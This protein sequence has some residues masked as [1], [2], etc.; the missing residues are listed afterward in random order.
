MPGYNAASFGSLAQLVEQRTFNPLV[1]GSSPAR[2]TMNYQEAHEFRF[3][4]FLRSGHPLVAS[5]K[6]AAPPCREFFRVDFLRRPACRVLPDVDDRTGLDSQVSEE[7]DGLV[8]WSGL[9]Y[10]T[11]LIKLETNKVLPRNLLSLISLN[12][13]KL[14]E[15]PF[16]VEPIYFEFTNRLLTCAYK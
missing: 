7:A 16:I 15:S 12:E 8:A 1:A 14:R 3:V 2:P 10:A 4:G 5:K 13:I 9:I 11:K 6:R